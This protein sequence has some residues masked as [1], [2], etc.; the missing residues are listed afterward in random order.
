M[1]GRRLAGDAMDELTAR[2]SKQLAVEE[3]VKLQLYHDTKGILSIG[4][5]RNIQSVGIRFDEA[6]LMLA[7]DIAANVAWLGQ[8]AWFTALSDVRKAAIVDMSF[9]GVERLLHFVNMIHY[10]TLQEWVQAGA[11]VANSQWFKDV[12]PHRGG[13]VQAMIETDQWPTDV[14]FQP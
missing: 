6:A 3:G 2:L 7:N 1:N 12:G 13:R 14:G 10:L 5:G 9:M 8:Y 4:V 11:E